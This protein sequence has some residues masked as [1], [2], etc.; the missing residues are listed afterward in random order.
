MRTQLK[1]IKVH[2]FVK[3]RVLRPS[4]YHQVHRTVSASD[5]TIQMYPGSM[6]FSLSQMRLYFLCRLPVS[7]WQNHGSA[8][9]PWGMRLR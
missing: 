5:V 4:G 8:S 3:P 1:T 7:F 9:W 6:S 2:L